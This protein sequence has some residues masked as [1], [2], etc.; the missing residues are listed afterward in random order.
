MVLSIEEKKCEHVAN[1]DVEWVVDSA[2]PH[3]IIPTKGFFITYKAGDFGIVKIGN[4]SYSKIVGIG[5]VCIETNVG[6]TMM[7]QD[8]RNVPDLRMIVFSILA[9]DRA[10]YCNY[11]RN[12]R[13][14]LTKGS[15]VVAKG[16][17]C[18]GLYR[19]QVKTYKKK[20][21]EIVEP[22]EK[23]TTGE[24]RIVSFKNNWASDEGEPKG[25][26]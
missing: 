12:G 23:K 26:D 18:C 19:T 5:D 2:A 10:I 8:V 9:M 6:S 1:N 7:L 25:L 24:H 4:S 11:L 22:H 20:F 13:C 16:H 17:A 21:N 14:K 15:L 3:H